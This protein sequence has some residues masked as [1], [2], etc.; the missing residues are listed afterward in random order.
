MRK[1]MS[2]LL[3]IILVLTLSS[4]NT[5]KEYKKT[6]IYFS[7]EI[8][9]TIYSNDSEGANKALKYGSELFEKY[10]NLTDRYNDYSGVKG[11]YYINNHPNEE[12]EIDLD[13]F[14]LLEYSIENSKLIKDE[15]NLPYFT[16]GIGKLSDIYHPLFL[17][18]EGLEIPANMFDKETIK[19]MAFDTDASKIILSDVNYTIRIPDSISL[20]LGGI[21]KGYAVEKLAEYYERENI[22]YIINAGAS[23][24]ITN[25][26]NP[27]RMNNEF[28]IGLKDPNTGI[29]EPIKI[30]G[31]LSVP[32]NKAVITSGDYQKYFIYDN[33]RYSHILS[34]STN[35][36][37]DT[38]IRSI[39]LITDS[40]AYG[41]ILSTTLFMMGSE[42]AIEYIENNSNVEGII[43]LSS[44]E[45]YVSDGLKTSFKNVK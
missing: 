26:G 3:L 39:T 21:A 1:L 2:F 28:I 9:I 38:D 41:D 8:E 45:F 19:N 11:I 4:C 22:K 35:L 10:N 6:Y 15:N 36:P 23:N 32:K 14:K 20:D 31:T 16:I 29:D 44:D 27:K 18:Y 24:I 7:T 17:E 13:L 25:F 40:N 42:K 30:Y 37:A 34:P 12:I 33:K 5:L 43:Y